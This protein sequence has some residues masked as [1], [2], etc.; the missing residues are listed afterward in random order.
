MNISVKAQTY[1]IQ[2]NVAMNEE[3]VCV[4]KGD[5]FD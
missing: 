1:V 4:I 2:E 3:R 5:M